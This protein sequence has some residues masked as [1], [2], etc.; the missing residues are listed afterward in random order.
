TVQP[1]NRVVVAVLEQNWA[2]TQ[3][4][5]SARSERAAFATY[6]EL[7]ELSSRLAAF[8]VSRGYKA[9]VH[10]TEGEGIAINFAVEAGLGQLGLN[11]QLLTPAAGS[12]IRIKLIT[13]D[14]P[15]VLDSPKD[16]GIE[17][18]CDACQACVK[19]C[20]SG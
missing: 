18:L 3:A 1:G 4:I 10:S 13:T 19:R 5:P 14:A 20:P 16:Y 17:A 2:A 8:L 9:H 7:L 12:R 15:L 6:A 11:G